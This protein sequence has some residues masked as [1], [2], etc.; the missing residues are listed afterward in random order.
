MI[1]Y[2]GRFGRWH[3]NE[4]TFGVVR[5]LLDAD[6]DAFFLVLTPDLEAARSLAE[7]SLPAGRYDIRKAAHA[8]VPRFLRASDLGVLLRAP[9]PINIAACPTK[10][11]EFAMTGLPVLISAG[12]GDCSGFVAS[13]RAGVV[14]ERPDPAAAVRGV[15]A[16]R[17]EPDAQRR[18]RI[19]A[20]GVARF[21]RARHAA[22]LAQ[23]YRGLV[24]ESSAR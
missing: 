24:G 5:G 6:P 14:L 12:I 16:L 2:P 11:G 3:Y 4:E 23:I 10:F 13:E 1:V 8:D 18:A 9:D 22:E 20:A 19:A 17:S 7:R 15:A 21:S